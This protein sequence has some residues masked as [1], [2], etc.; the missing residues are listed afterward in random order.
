[1]N[2]KLVLLRSSSRKKIYG[3]LKILVWNGK[4]VFVRCR[5]VDFEKTQTKK[6]LKPNWNLFTS[7]S[8]FYICGCHKR[9]VLLFCCCCPFQTVLLL[10]VE[11]T[12]WDA[13][14]LV[15]IGG[16][17][18]TNSVVV[19]LLF[20]ISPTRIQMYTK[21]KHSQSAGL[22]VCGA[23]QQQ[24]T[25]NELMFVVICVLVAL[26]YTAECGEISFLQWICYN[27]SLR[28]FAYFAKAYSSI[29]ISHTKR[30]QVFVRGLIL[31]GTMISLKGLWTSKICF[32]YHILKVDDD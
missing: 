12:A 29:A 6:A 20:R 1:M 28:S 32:V 25:E 5:C 3:F 8:V 13:H 21:K 15:S 19:S 26:P 18:E 24:Q 27:S 23:T 7:D 10:F 11:L 17:T 9:F 14:N 31:F 2:T 22:G 16:V 4:I 30:I